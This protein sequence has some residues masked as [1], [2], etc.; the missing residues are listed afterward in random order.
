M[1][2]IIDGS[3]SIDIDKYTGLSAFPSTI[4]ASKPANL[5]SEPQNSP[6]SAFGDRIS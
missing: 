6:A 5:S 1:L 3:L 4:T 2:S